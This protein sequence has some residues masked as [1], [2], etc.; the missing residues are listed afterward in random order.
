MRGRALLPALLA[1]LLTLSGCWDYREISST[2]FIAGAAFDPDPLGGYILTA[3]IMDFGGGRDDAPAVTRITA[4]GATIPEAADHAM[5][6]VGKRLYW[7]HAA[8]FIVSRELAEQGITPLT[9]FLLHNIDTALTASLLVSALPAAGDVLDLR[10]AGTGAVS[11]E[12]RSIMRN[13]AYFSQTVADFAYETLEDLETGGSCAVLAMAGASEQDG[14]RFLDVS[15]CAVFDGFRMAA[16]LDALDTPRLLALRGKPVGGTLA[17]TLPDGSACMLRFTDTHTAFD[18]QV[19]SDGQLRM[20]VHMDADTVVSSAP[21]LTAPTDTGLF[22]AL[23]QAAEARICERLRELTDRAQEEQ[24]LDLFGF[25]ARFAE[26]MPEAWPA[27]EAD[28]NRRF[29]E[30]EIALSAEVRIVGSAPGPVS[31]PGEG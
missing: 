4:R 13:N 7:S 23:E 19:L 25:G 28:W 8:A 18:P 20:A 9:D 6:A 11:Y 29:A 31:L 24:G 15:G 21:T 1:A 12:I 22:E 10:I 2:T 5:R 27:W 17:L 26:A 16:R 14:E 30:M 3:E